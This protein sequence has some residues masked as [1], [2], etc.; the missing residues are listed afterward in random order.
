MTASSGTHPEFRSVHK[1]VRIPRWLTYPL[2]FWN[3]FSCVRCVLQLLSAGTL[4]LLLE[5]SGANNASFQNSVEGGAIVVRK[6]FNFSTN[7]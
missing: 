5:H 3:E 2:F 1:P 4:L 7:V 6:P